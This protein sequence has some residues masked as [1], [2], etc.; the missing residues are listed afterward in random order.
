MSLIDDALVDTGHPGPRGC[1][2]RVLEHHPEL[3]PKL[4]EALGMCADGTM[5]YTG[6][7]RSLAR[8]DVH[9]SAQSLSRHVRGTCKCYR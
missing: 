7:S 5:A 8:R 9:L 3:E 6:L 1:V 2:E 4:T